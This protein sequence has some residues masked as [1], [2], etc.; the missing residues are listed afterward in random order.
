MAFYGRCEINNS[1]FLSFFLV[2]FL[3]HCSDFLC[4]GIS[5]GFGLVVDIETFLQSCGCLDIHSPSLCW[6][7]YQEELD[8]ILHKV[9]VKEKAS[10]L[11]AFFSFVSKTCFGKYFFMMLLQYVL[12]IISLYFCYFSQ[13]VSLR[14]EWL[15]LQKQSIFI[16]S[17]IL[18]NYFLTFKL[19][20][21]LR[22][23]SAQ[24]ST[25]SKFTSEYKLAFS[26]ICPVT[27][28]KS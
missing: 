11:L 2:L 22:I 16:I 10:K 12:G 13:S 7:K 1:I 14:S 19:E 23:S 24:P 5:L 3:N 8:K 9:L 4:L 6:N 21:T 27:S 28:Q 26:K 17:R 25:Q 20:G 15:L 18:Y